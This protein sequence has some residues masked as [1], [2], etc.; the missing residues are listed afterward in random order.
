M[1]NALA[2]YSNPFMAAA[3]IGFSCGTA[4]SPLVTFFNY[5]YDVSA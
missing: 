2:D 3:A 1:S 5:L 4:C